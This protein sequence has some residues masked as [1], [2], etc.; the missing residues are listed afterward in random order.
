MKQ[1]KAIH[2]L[3]RFEDDLFR[4]E[5]EIFR[6]EACTGMKQNTLLDVRKFDVLWSRA[7]AISLSTL[8]MQGI[9]LSTNNDRYSD[10]LGPYRYCWAIFNGL[11]GKSH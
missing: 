6:N 4:N 1:L 5:A 11:R 8:S 10:Q 9:Y 2:D 3:F 7:R